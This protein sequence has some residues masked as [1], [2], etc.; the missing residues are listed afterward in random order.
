MPKPRTTLNVADALTRKA[1]APQ[2][3]WRLER[4]GEA[5]GLAATEGRR[6]VLEKLQINVDVAED[7]R[8]RMECFQAWMVVTQVTT[9]TVMV[10]GWAFLDYLDDLFLSGFAHGDGSKNWSALKHFVPTVVESTVT[11]ARVQ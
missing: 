6:T 2:G 11:V 3:R 10:L 1:S 9:V 5:S 8:S 4:Y 7:H